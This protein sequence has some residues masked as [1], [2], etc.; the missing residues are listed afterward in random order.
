MSHVYRKPFSAKAGSTTGAGGT[1]SSTGPLKA[2]HTIMTDAT[3]Q[4]PSMTS[5]VPEHTAHGRRPPSV[6]S[7]G[8]TSSDDRLNELQREFN[9]LMDLYGRLKELRATPE[10]DRQMDALLDVS[11]PVTRRIVYVHVACSLYTYLV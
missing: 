5:S 9:D 6:A 3:R 7:D 2:D 1:A 8:M 4:Q 11:A 10:R